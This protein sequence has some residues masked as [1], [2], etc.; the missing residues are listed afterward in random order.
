MSEETNKTIQKDGTDAT[1]AA[2]PAGEKT[3]TGQQRE[4]LTGQ[5]LEKEAKLKKQLR[6]SE[7]GVKEYQYFIIR[8]AVLLLL[9]WALFFQVVGLTHMPSGDMYPRLDLGDLVLFY[10]LDKD[11]RAQDV[12]AI[13]KT[14]PDT[15]ETKLFICRV[16]AA[17]GDT[18]EITDEGRLKVNGNVMI[19]PNIFYATPRYE[20]YTEF[21]L[22]LGPGECFVLADKRDGGADSRYFGPVSR[23]EILGTVITIVRRNAL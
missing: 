3:V 22:T 20:G 6:R 16:V 14:T 10:R 11:V 21:P 18:V 2:A 9:I 19:E 7:K 23:D 4:E 8:L 1:A 13:E 15:K 12:I 5:S 17:Q